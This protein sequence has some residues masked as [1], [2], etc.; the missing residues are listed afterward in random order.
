MSEKEENPA[1][2]GT[3][4]ALAAI[5]LALASLGAS[6]WA[7][8][9]ASARFDKIARRVQELEEAVILKPAPG[10]HRVDGD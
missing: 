2:S 9:V 5:L 4:H 7:A 6:A 1:R 10:A 3:W 8:T